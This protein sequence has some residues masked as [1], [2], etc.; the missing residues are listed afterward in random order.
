MLAL[1]I[2]PDPAPAG[3]EKPC[4]DLVDPKRS[5][6]RVDAFPRLAQVSNADRYACLDVSHPGFVN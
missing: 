3:D 5:D 2:S 6:Y 4:L 1:L